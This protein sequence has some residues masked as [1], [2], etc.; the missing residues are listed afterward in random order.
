MY[1]QDPEGKH[2]DRQEKDAYD[3]FEERIV[4]IGI[5]ILA[6]WKE[7]K[8]SE[9]ISHIVAFLTLASLIF[10]AAYTV[11]IYKANVQSAEAAKESARAVKE[12]TQRAYRPWLGKESIVELKADILGPPSDDTV[13]GQLSVAV[14]NFGPSP[15]LNAGLGAKPFIR[16][17]GDDSDFTNARQ[18]ACKEADVLAMISGT[19][20]FPQQTFQLNTP[21]LSEVKGVTRITKAGG[22]I[23]VAGCIA[24]R[25]QFDT[26]HTTHHT[27][28]CVMGKIQKLQTLYVCDIQE[29][30]D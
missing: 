12:G 22:T 2:S 26:T 23:L 14:K 16:T 20:V 7:L 25:D 30:A 5:A 6:I 10:Y 29:I 21:V 15:A 28:F 11:K 3:E 9:R 27:S 17:T 4:R 19:S 8:M 13:A 1:S 24:Y 18:W